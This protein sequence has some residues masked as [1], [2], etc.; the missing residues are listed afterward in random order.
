M[1]WLLLFKTG[2]LWLSLAQLGSCWL[3]SPSFP[4]INLFSCYVR[5]IRTAFNVL[6]VEHAHDNIGLGWVRV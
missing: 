5:F 6:V 3:G 4:E 2:W 1:H